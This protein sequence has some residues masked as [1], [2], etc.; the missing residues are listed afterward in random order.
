MRNDGLGYS[1]RALKRILTWI[2]MFVMNMLRCCVG[3]DDKLALEA[4]SCNCLTARQ[5]KQP[6]DERNFGINGYGLTR[7]DMNGLKTAGY[8]NDKNKEMTYL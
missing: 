6:T 7:G 8:K 5:S 3:Y 4:S 2:H 1:Y